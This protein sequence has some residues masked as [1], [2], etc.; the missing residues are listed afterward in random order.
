MGIFL[1]PLMHIIWLCYGKCVFLKGAC[2]V[3]RLSGQ[4]LG[5]SE[6]WLGFCRRDDPEGSSVVGVRRARKT[7]TDG[8]SGSVFSRGLWAV[9]LW[10]WSIFRLCSSMWAPKGGSASVYVHLLMFAYMFAYIFH[11]NNLKPENVKAS[12]RQVFK[13]TATFLF[14]LFLSQEFAM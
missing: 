13:F 5:E 11:I 8:K 3:N 10:S 6:M 9:V 7:Q 2:P 4:L 1:R 12:D 14:V